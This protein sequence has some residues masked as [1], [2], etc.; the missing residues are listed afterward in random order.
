MGKGLASACPEWE[1]EFHFRAPNARKSK[2]RVLHVVGMGNGFP[3]R[4]PRGGTV[5]AA[6][7]EDAR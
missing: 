6:D 4:P 1:M 2:A 5:P 3:M 7:R